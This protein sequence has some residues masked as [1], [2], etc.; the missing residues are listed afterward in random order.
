MLGGYIY[1]AISTNKCIAFSILFYLYILKSNS[2]SQFTKI[3]TIVQNLAPKLI[4]EQENFERRNG[5]DCF[6]VCFFH[7]KQLITIQDVS[8]LQKNEKQWPSLWSWRVMSENFTYLHI[9]IFSRMCQRWVFVKDGE[10]GNILRIP[11][12]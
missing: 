5:R 2:V 3:K 11:L 4:F 1:D 7:T 10:A 9:K 8:H 6:F 12:P